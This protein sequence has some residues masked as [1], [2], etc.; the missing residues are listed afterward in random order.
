MALL[1]DLSLDQ[2]VFLADEASIS[3]TYYS[4]WSY[5]LQLGSVDK[6]FS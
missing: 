2:F 3:A 5:S 4:T 1:F 6:L